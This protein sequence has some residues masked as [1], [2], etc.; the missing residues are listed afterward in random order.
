MAQQEEGWPLGLQPLNVRVGLVHMPE[1]S[2][3]LSF[4]TSPSASPSSSDL[5]T[6]ST[7]SFFHDKSITLGSLIGVSNILE[8]SR[9]SL[10]KRR[11][12]TVQIKKNNRPKTWCFSLCPRDQTDAESDCHNAAS[13]GHFLAVE[14]R[15]EHRRSHSPMIYG[16]EDIALAQESREQNS[17]FVD[18]HVAPPQLSPWA[19][20]DNERRREGVLNHTNRC[21]VPLVFHCICCQHIH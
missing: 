9:R 19:C 12:Q 3:S 14:R 13:L 11:P 1:F 8:F 7:G 5:D 17:L 18:G 21:G 20:S 4:N 16:P 6:E 10:R 2:G 15:A